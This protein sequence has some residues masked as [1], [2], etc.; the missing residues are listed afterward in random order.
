MLFNI[1]I[2]VIFIAVQTKYH[3]YLLRKMLA[4]DYNTILLS[5]NF[6]GTTNVITIITQV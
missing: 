2:I 1:I 5:G 6:K 3:K 4:Y